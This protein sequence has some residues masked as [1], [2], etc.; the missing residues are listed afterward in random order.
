MIRQLTLVL[1]AVV[2]VIQIVS[3]LSKVGNAGKTRQSH[4]NKMKEYFFEAPPTQVQII[5]SI[6]QQLGNTAP[7]FHMFMFS[8]TSDKGFR[9]ARAVVEGETL[10]VNAM[11]AGTYADN[12]IQLQ[13][14]VWT[15]GRNNANMFYADFGSPSNYKIDAFSTIDLGQIPATFRMAYTIFRASSNQ[16]WV[17]TAFLDNKAEPTKMWWVI[18]RI[19]TGGPQ[20]YTDA[21]R[22]FEVAL[23]KQST[24]VYTTS[25]HNTNYRVTNTKPQ[26][27]V[28]EYRI[29]IN[30]TNNTLTIEDLTQGK[31]NTLN[32]M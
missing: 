28:F 21:V 30:R 19:Q 17:Y 25:I 8:Q 18:Q 13:N 5:I 2:L 15:Y 29:T 1:L 26:E 23:T 12:K 7:E 9:Y 6:E 22:K 11:K 31:S 16:Y 27:T 3:I 20:V 24:D 4:V 32:F 14:E 10:R